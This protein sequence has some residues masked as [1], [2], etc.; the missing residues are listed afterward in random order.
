MCCLAL[1]VAVLF[2]LVSCFL[3]NLLSALAWA[4]IASFYRGVTWA[5]FE[6]PARS[7]GALLLDFVC[8]SRFENDLCGILPCLGRDVSHG[9]LRLPKFLRD[10]RCCARHNSGSCPA[11]GH[12]AADP[13]CPSGPAHGSVDPGRLGGL[14]GPSCDPPLSRRGRLR[15]LCTCPPSGRYCP[16]RTVERPSCFS[17][18][19]GSISCG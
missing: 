7:P 16:C 5:L 17:G 18:F 2:L 11:D 1:A 15:G 3:C 13:V 19:A 4:Q 9:D 6:D 10:L 8:C 14:R 12:R